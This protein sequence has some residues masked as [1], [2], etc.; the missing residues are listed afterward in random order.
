MTKTQV[1]LRVNGRTHELW[2]GTN[3]LLLDALHD[4]LGMADVRYGCGEGV[5]GTCTIL[6]DGEPV[7]ACLLFAVQ[8]EGREITTLTGLPAADAESHPIQDCF[9][10]AGAAQCGFCTPGMMLTALALVERTERPTREDI[11]YELVGNLCRCTGY[12]KI[13]DAVE[14]YACRRRGNGSHD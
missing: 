2:V 14:E 12:T 5:C 6:L 9:L 7:S 8:V 3:R 10:Q 11:R 4:D 1:Q 13:V